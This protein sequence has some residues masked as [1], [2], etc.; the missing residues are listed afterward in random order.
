VSTPKVSL[1]ASLLG[2]GIVD[3]VIDYQKQNVVKEIGK[4]KVD[5]MLDTH[6]LAMS[7]LE[8]MRG[9]GKGLVLSL[10]GK[11]GSHLKEDWPE[12]PWWLVKILDWVD[13]LFV[14]RAG[15]WG[16]IYGM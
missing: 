5:F 15:R 9:E 12:T 10:T 7:Y 8:V 13:A 6:F 11:S 2:D 14:W 16:V 3:Q 4:G 1:L